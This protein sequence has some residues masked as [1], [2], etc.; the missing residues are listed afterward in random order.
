MKLPLAVTYTQRAASPLSTPGGKAALPRA[1]LP[2][3]HQQR[4]IAVFLSAS[5]PTTNARPA[6]ATACPCR[7]L[8]VLSTEKV[9]VL[10][11][12]TVQHGTTRQ[13]HLALGVWKG[14]LLDEVLGEGA[15]HCRTVG[16]AQKQGCT[17]QQRTR[18]TVTPY[19]AVLFQA[20]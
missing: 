16:L 18:C 12:E 20:G 17:A 7:R 3:P 2:G 6:N 10:Y 8:S 15:C 9:Q 19:I 5:P 11:Q 13:Q 14:V 1:P 4:T